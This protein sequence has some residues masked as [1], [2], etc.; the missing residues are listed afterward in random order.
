[1][2]ILLHSAS[3]LK[4]FANFSSAASSQDGD[5]DNKGDFDAPVRTKRAQH[6]DAML[7]ELIQYRNK[8]GDTLV[9][10]EY[11]LNPKLGTWGESVHRSIT[12]VSFLLSLNCG[13]FGLIPYA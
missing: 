2:K 3:H 6:W 10:A 9:P 4:M 13:L 8:H 12:F 5:G 7:E 11:D 1:M